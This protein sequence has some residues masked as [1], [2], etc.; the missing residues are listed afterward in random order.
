MKPE[1]DKLNAIVDYCQ[2]NG[3]HGRS[4]FVR[5]FGFIPR[6]MP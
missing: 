2:K 1:K 4:E 6:E 3:I 5:F